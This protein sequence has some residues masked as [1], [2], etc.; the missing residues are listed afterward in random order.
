VRVTTA[1]NLLLRLSGVTVSAVA[2]E[3]GQVLV[4]VRLRQRRLVCPHCGYSTRWR[5][6]L[7][8]DPS[9]WRALDLGV[10]RV[11][12]RSRLRRLACPAHGVVVEA[13]P[14]ARHGARFTRDVEDLVAWLATKTDKT[15]ITR[16]LRVNWR[17][18]GAIVERV[19]ADE[20][21]PHRLDDL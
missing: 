18:V 8:A 7:Q 10:W 4:D 1:F 12:V 14:F 19:V 6:N 21:D 11:V 5:H 3:P 16:L 20:L 15:A 13:V 2:F 9:T 17:T